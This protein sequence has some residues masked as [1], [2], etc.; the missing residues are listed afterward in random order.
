MPASAV[1]ATSGTRRARPW[2]SEHGAQV[3]DA[4]LAGVLTGSSLLALATGA[5]VRR[6]ALVA[7]VR[8]EAVQALAQERAALARELHDVVTHRLTTMVVQADAAQTRL[9]ERSGE[10]SATLKTIAASGR[11]ALAELRELLTVLQQDPAGP[12]IP[13]RPPPGLADLPILLDR[14]GR[15]GRPVTLTVQGECHPLP[16]EMQRAMYRIVQESLTNVLRHGGDVSGDVTVRY[17]EGM[18]ELEI[19]NGGP[20]AGVVAAPVPTR[21]GTIG[22]RHRAAMLGGELTAGPR[23]DG[24]YRVL[25]RLPDPGSS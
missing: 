10:V 21:R 24:G 23:P 19:S 2:I 13:V 6:R 22:M 14:A 8:G 15:P 18:V 11:E 25:V 16:P 9:D 7:R 4:L 1:A 3:A 12:P 17:G 20:P 5:E